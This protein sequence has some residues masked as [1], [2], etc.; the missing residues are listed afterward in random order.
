[1]ASSAIVVAGG[2][3]LAS[4]YNNMRKDVVEGQLQYYALGGS[5][6]AFTFTAD[7]QYTAYVTGSFFLVKA[8][9]AIDGAATLN[10]SGLGAKTIK[11]P[12]G[13][14]V[15]QGDII[16]G[17]LF[18]VEY[19]GTNFQMLSQGG[20]PSGSF[21][22]LIVAGENITVSGDPVPVY[23][24]D[25]TGGR[26][27]GRFYRA[28]A[29]DTTNMAQGSIYFLKQSSTSGSTY[30]V[31]GGIIT[32]FASLTLN[33][34][35]FLSDTVGTIDTTP[36]TTIVPVGRPISTTILD[37]ISPLTMK[38]VEGALTDVVDTAA[39]TTNWDETIN[40]GFYAVYIEVEYYIEGHDS[41][42]ST[43]KYYSEWG[44]ALWKGTTIVNTL[45]IAGGNSISEGVAAS[46]LSSFTTP[47][48]ASAPS[49]GTGGGNSAETLTSLSINALTATGFTFRTTVLSQ[50]SGNTGRMRGRYR[51]WG[52]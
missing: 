2:D 13:D 5:S 40:L 44:K 39:G 51:A 25:G 10:V 50:A 20:L 33:R 19:D 3:I 28:D 12:N 36:G 48:D 22:R 7:T 30:P 6:N 27:S 23:I 35:Y 29:N 46:T 38:M 34:P 21:Y 14:D 47:T 9:F 17:Q 31:F 42:A 15:A 41:S 1:M 52:Y 24:S 49:A 45:T 4:Q 43:A 11:K 18:L 26:T 37:T 8:N 32:G 16:N